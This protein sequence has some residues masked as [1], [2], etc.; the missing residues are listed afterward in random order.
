MTH[1]LVTAIADLVW[2]TLGGSSE[3][4]ERCE[5]E[6][7]A[8]ETRLVGEKVSKL[9]SDEAQLSQHLAASEKLLDSEHSRKAGIESR[10]LNTAGLV[11]IAGTVVLGSL[12][13]LATEKVILERHLVKTILSVGC[14]YLALQL[15]AALHASVRGLQA[16]GYVED[17][18]NDVIP[19]ADTTLRFFLRYRVRQVLVRVAEH[20][21]VN[22]KKI[23]QLKIAHTAMHNFLWGLLCVAAAACLISCFGSYGAQSLSNG[24]SLSELDTTI[25]KAEKLIAELRLGSS[26]GAHVTRNSTFIQR[27]VTIGPFPDGNHFLAEEDVRKCVSSALAP[28][29]EKRIGGWEVIGRVD[30]RQLRPDRAEVYGSNQALAMARANWVAQKV[31]TSQQSFEITN[32]IVSVGGARGVGKVVGVSDLQSDRVVDVF[33]V[34]NSTMSEKGIPELPKSVICPPPVGFSQ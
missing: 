1:K 25:S 6:K 34:V 19:G 20:R 27:L 24:N 23:D 28:Y 8:E 7:L 33:V 15:V 9:G 3:E 5:Q 31:L 32:A 29:K 2:P 21:R 14:F 17:Q 10:L 26:L 16:T 12:F 22:N 4:H 11:S 18:P 13:S 30:K